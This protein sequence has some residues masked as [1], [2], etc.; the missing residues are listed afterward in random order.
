MLRLINSGGRPE[1]PVNPGPAGV[2]RKPLP[3]CDACAT[4]ADAS[5]CMHVV[6]PDLVAVLCRDGAACC[7]RYRRG[8][9]PDSFAAGL[10]G[11]ILGI[12]S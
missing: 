6:G 1:V 11:E 12:A 4:D 2:Q 3:P 9:S 7:R 5:R 10:R 8:A